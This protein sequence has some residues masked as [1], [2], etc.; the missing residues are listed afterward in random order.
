MTTTSEIPILRKKRM[1]KVSQQSRYH[2]FFKVTNA[3]KW[4]FS[5]FVTYL[6]DINDDDARP[7]AAVNVW[8]TNTTKLTRD[9][10][11]PP[12][13]RKFTSELLK[14]RIV[15]CDCEMIRSAL[16][17][18]EE[19]S[20]FKLIFEPKIALAKQIAGASKEFCSTAVSGKR[21]RVFASYVMSEEE[22]CPKVRKVDY[23]IP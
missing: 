22:P 2:N 8:L 9:N 4:S 19:F 13:V 23:M 14:L 15:N 18:L 20:S 10:S 6:I 3:E 11:V 7:F 17:S 21:D 12:P 1:Y 16:N 5:N